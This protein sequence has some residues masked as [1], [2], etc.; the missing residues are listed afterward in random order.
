MIV[1]SLTI[2]SVEVLGLLEPIQ[3]ALSPVTV[4]WLGLRSEAGIT[5]LFG[6]LRKEL[7]LMML[8]TLLGTTD[9][10]AALTL[11]QMITYTLVVMLYIPCIA[12]VAACVKEFGWKKAIFITIFEMAFATLVG[13][14]TYRIPLLL[15]VG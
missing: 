14:V 1:G 13:G 2:K 3:L 12:I 5:L 15:G 6:I 4:W 7:T 9:F 10:G 11:V 8:A